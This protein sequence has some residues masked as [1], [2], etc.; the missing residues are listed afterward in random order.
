MLPGVVVVGFE[1]FDRLP[2]RV[3]AGD[4]WLVDGEPLLLGVDR[5]ADT[6]M[7]ALWKQAF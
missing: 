7:T 5:T 4:A 3:L 6:M 1:V 2:S